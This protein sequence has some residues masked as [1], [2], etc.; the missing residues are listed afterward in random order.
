[1]G[2]KIAK[3]IEVY[4]C[5]SIDDL[6]RQSNTDW[7]VEVM[8]AHVD[9]AAGRVGNGGFRALVRPDINQALAF[10]GERFRTNSHRAQ[11]HTLDYM[12]SNGT[13]VPATVSMW[14]NGAIL[15]YQFRC[16]GL[17]VTILDKDVVSPLLTLAFAYGSQLAD[18]AFF[19]DFRW[20]CKNQLGRVAKL[21]SDSK[22]KH[23]GDIV[24]NY[25]NILTE[26]IGELGSELQDRYNAMKRMVGS[27]LTGRALVEYFGQSL[28]M[29][30][31]DI[32]HAWT[33]PKEDLVGPAKRIPEVFD[34][35][36]VDDCGAEGT[37]WQAY[38]AVTRYETHQAGRTAETRQ[39]RMLLGPG[40]DVANN[41]FD[42]AS[43]VAA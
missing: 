29:S 16:P 22:V 23:R 38:N 7:D 27:K 33:I 36:M 13:I 14:D 31:T 34:C 8:D 35:Y 40:S 6:L 3:V 42:L 17:D 4:N 41:A 26:R 20:F 28:G 10:V 25:G 24:S 2:N 18:S 9:T 19:S 21:T 11:L 12:V 37:V 39:R 1:M 5:M 43:K 15:A 32:Q 30:D